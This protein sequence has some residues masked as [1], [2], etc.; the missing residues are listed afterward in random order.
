MQNDIV[1]NKY[2]FQLFAQS[3][4]KCQVKSSVKR[5]YKND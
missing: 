5:Y 1:N 2:N 3:A 4:S